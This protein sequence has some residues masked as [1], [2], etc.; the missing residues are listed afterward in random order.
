MYATMSAQEL[1]LQQ[2]KQAREEAERELAALREV[3]QVKEDQEDLV[4][5][6]SGEV[7]FESGKDALLPTA[8]RKLETVAEVLKRKE[9]AQKQF[10]VVGH[11]DDQGNDDF[12]QDLSRRRAE[13]VRAFLVTHGMQADHIVAIGRGESQPVASNDNPEGRANNRRVEIIVGDEAH[14]G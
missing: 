10:A 6:L 1:Q 14:E 5:T 11:T 9:V 7:L 8:Q 12:N 3:A 2:E 13:A 4:I